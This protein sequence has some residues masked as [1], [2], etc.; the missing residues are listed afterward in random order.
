MEACSARD[1]FDM[2]IE[3]PQL[4]GGPPAMKVISVFCSGLFRTLGAKSVIWNSSK[5]Q[6]DPFVLCWSGDGTVPP[7]HSQ[8]V[9]PGR[10]V[11]V[12]DSISDETTLTNSYFPADLVETTPSWLSCPPQHAASSAAAFGRFP[13]GARS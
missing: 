1:G 8:S 12:L 2:R 13:K 3:R 11:L 4:S 6:G 7:S 5:T 10:N 9:L